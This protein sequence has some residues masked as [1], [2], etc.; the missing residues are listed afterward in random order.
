MGGFDLCVNIWF[1][2]EREEGKNL[3]LLMARGTLFW[4]LAH[5]NEHVIICSGGCQWT[6]KYYGWFGVSFTTLSSLLF[7]EIISFK[8][9]IRGPA[10]ENSIVVNPY[11]ACLF[12]VL[13]VVDYKLDNVAM[14]LS[15]KKK[16]WITWQVIIY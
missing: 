10:H 4:Y 11:D 16:N 12:Y 2:V 15:K 3:G 9:P 8:T 1:Q 13:L 7:L 14:Y 5:Q 6:F